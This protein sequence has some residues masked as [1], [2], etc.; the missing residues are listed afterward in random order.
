[1]LV[2]TKMSD[3]KTVNACLPEISLDTGYALHIVIIAWDTVY[4]HTNAHIDIFGRA[5]EREEREETDPDR[6]GITGDEAHNT[7]I[8]NVVAPHVDA[9]PGIRTT[10]PVA[11]CEG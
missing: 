9:C 11:S 6:L 5:S 4:Y 7:N 2:A 8:A 3:A 10:E 1:M